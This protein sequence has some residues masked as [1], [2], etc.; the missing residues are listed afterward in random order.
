MNKQ[1][2]TVRNID[3]ARRLTLAMGGIPTLRL[4]LAGE[5]PERRPARNL[6]ASRAEL[7]RIYGVRR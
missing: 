2:E 7:K 4:A 6:D 1:A 5:S 3:L